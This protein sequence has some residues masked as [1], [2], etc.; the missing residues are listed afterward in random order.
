MKVDI[1]ARQYRKHPDAGK[2]PK[3]W[4]SCGEFTYNTFKDND[5]YEVR[6]LTILPEDVNHEQSEL[7]LT[8]KWNMEMRTR[9]AKAEQQVLQLK[10]LLVVEKKKHENELSA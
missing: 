7:I 9:L 8:R 3:V 5:K 1:I 4:E 10:N 2:P 6:R